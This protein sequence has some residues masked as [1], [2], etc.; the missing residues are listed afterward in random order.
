[1]KNINQ[2]FLILLI[3]VSCNK[4]NNVE[5]IQSDNIEGCTIEEFYARMLING[6][7]WT[8]SFEFFVIENS[9]IRIRMRKEEK[10]EEEFLF[11]IPIDLKLGSRSVLT[12]SEYLSSKLIVSE[13]IDAIVA[14]FEPR[15]D[16]EKEENWIIVDSID[17]D[18][19]IISGKFETI[20][21]SD[22]SLGSQSIYDRPDKLVI[23][24][25]QF[26][27]KRIE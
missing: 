2:I 24:D 16:L 9:I 21:Y 14:R 3:C 23:T 8:S 4:E 11:K 13:G 25:G 17:V 22:S 19:T 18:S 27:I 6:E 20:L 26:R 15:Y 7:C 10:F 1:M 5:P 12:G